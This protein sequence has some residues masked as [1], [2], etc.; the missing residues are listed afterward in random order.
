MDYWNSRRSDIYG[1]RGICSSSQPL[2]SAVGVKVL[3]T[4]G[5]AADAA[6][7][8]AATLNLTEPCSTGIGGDAFALYYEAKTKK[9]HCLQGNGK[10]SV[11]TTLESLRARGIGIGEGLSNWD[12]RS[13]LCVTVP[14]AA[15]L[16]ENLVEKFGSMKLLDVLQPAINLAEEG[17]PISPV[18]SKYW[19]K[20]LLQGEEAFR[21]LRPN[22]QPVLPGHFF[23]NP[24][25]AN[26]FRSLGTLGAKKGFYSGPVAEAIVAAVKEY[27]GDLTLEDLA[28]HETYEE[29]P[30]STVYKGIRVYQTPPPSHG[31]SVLLA[32]NVLQALEAQ[33]TVADGSHI[34][35]K[36]SLAIFSKQ[37]PTAE[38]THRAIQAMRHGFAD[39]LQYIC[40]PLHHPHSDTSPM[41]TD[42]LLSERYTQQRVQSILNIASAGDPV[43]P[44]DLTPFIQGETVYFC[45]VD[46]EGNACSMINSNYMGFGTGIVPK[47]TGFTLQNRGYNFSLQPGHPNQ[48]EGGKRPYHTI[49]PGLATYEEDDSLYGVFGN[50]VSALFLYF[51]NFVLNIFAGRFYAAHGTC[52]IASSYD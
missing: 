17:F 22:N 40:D 38:Q 30:I 43:Y 35:V 31:L 50:M 16:W 15:G 2:A 24:D 44:G 28:S 45:C 14:G 19:S 42:V 48:I 4:G 5:N 25:L 23:R 21:V 12:C 9:V 8:M 26:T 41:P 27:G 32:L 1:N 34:S 39:A 3:Q 36:D 18:T 51:F 6:I 49:I 20:G 33:S 10:S 47:N 7:A 37:A 52:A 13:G 46:A 11:H 29:A